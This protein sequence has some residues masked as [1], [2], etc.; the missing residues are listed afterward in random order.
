MDEFFEQEFNGVNYV[1]EPLAKG[2]YECCRFIGCNFSGA[3]IKHI[4]FA[5]CVFVDCNLSMV[6]VQG[7]AI[8]E[9]AFRNCKML[10]FRFDQ[11]TP[12]L[13]SFKFE[14]CQLNYAVFTALGIK[15]TTFVGCNLEDA[16]F[17]QADL[18]KATFDNCSLLRAQF[19]GANLTQADL[20]TASDFS[21][22]P[23]RTKLSKARFSSHNLAGLLYRYQLVIS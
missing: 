11:C 2:E 19:D 14:H 5:E 22:D 15:Q 6:Q 13:M 4:K 7:T 10:G 1:D 17:T 21:I 20:R 9:C 12:M 8:R 23:E 3:D 16:D 18:T